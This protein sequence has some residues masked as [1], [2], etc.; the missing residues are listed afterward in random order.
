MIWYVKTRAV[1]IPSRKSSR[2]IQKPFTTTE[3]ERVLGRRGDLARSVEMTGLGCELVADNC[4]G[5]GERKGVG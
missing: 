4:A 2:T 3:K 5:S 1:V